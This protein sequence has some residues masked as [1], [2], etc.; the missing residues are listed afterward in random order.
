MKAGACRIA[1]GEVDGPFPDQEAGVGAFLL[2]CSKV[3]EMRATQASLISGHR[4]RDRGRHHDR[5]IT[6]RRDCHQVSAA[7]TKQAISA[8]RAKVPK[9]PMTAMA[10]ADR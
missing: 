5:T 4:A 8:A 1:V 3:V 2:A 6:L 10:G 7:Q 9:A